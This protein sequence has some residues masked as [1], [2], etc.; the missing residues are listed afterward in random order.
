MTQ[1]VVPQK[2]KKVKVV[3]E[4]LVLGNGFRLQE[5]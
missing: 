3:F 4:A 5:V 1:S 2:D